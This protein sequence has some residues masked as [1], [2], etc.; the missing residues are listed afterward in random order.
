M[1]PIRAVAIASLAIAAP[2]SA[3]DLFGSAPPLSVPASQAPT[4]VEIGSNWYVRGDA[5]VSFSAAPDIVLPILPS[6]PPG[7]LA[8]GPASSGTGA[9]FTGD[10]GFGYRFNN[11]VRFD[12]IWDYWT[13]PSR[14]RSF[15]VVCPYGLEGVTTNSGAPAGYLFDPTNTCAG[16]TNFTQHNDAFLANGYVDLGTYAGFTPYIGGGLGLNVG[17][18]QGSASFA[19][20]ATGAVYAANLVNPGSF[21]SVWVNSAGQ[22]INP[23]PNIPFVW[24][25]WNRSI[26]ATTYRFAFD[27][28]AGLA[29]QIS[30]SALLDVGYRY[31]NGGQS[32]L[33]L[34]PQTGLTV[35][36]HNVS[37]QILVGVRYFL[38]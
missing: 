27:L 29:Y 6:L 21:P 36:Q 22:P 23:A 9:G 19:E 17:F 34:N 13:A 5:G 32:S 38:Q 12:A 28:T 26:N 16:T 1:T 15:A 37:Q 33:L 25:S 2:A 30:P 3:A 20:T 4:A 31:L 14:T 7:L 18:L 24:Q 10:L 35:K 11:F 8:A